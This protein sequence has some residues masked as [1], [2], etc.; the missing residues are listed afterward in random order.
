M[1]CCSPLLISRFGFSLSCFMDASPRRLSD[2][3]DVPSVQVQDEYFPDFAFGSAMS[4]LEQLDL[5]F[6]LDSVH[7]LFSKSSSMDVLD[8][9]EQDDVPDYLSPISLVPPL[10]PPTPSPS[11]LTLGETRNSIDPNEVCMGRL[12]SFLAKS[13]SHEERMSIEL[14]FPVSEMNVEQ[15]FPGEE[16][17]PLPDRFSCSILP[18]CPPMEKDIMP[19]PFPDDEENESPF[20]PCEWKEEDEMESVEQLTKKTKQNHTWEETA[21]RLQLNMSAPEMSPFSIPGRDG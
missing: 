1:V 20:D 15:P 17:L 5:P 6:S 3:G 11:T 14:P 9:R 21:C 4:P 10:Y 8:W 16:P 12:P 7:Q 19:L 18:A 13:Q 2:V